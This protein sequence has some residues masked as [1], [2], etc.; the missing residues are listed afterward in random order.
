MHKRISAFLT[1]I[2]FLSFTI[3]AQQIQDQW[4][5]YRGYK[6]CGVID[7][8]NLPNYWDINQNKN[9]KW[10]KDIE[11]LGMSNPVIW[12]DKLLI[13]TA[14][15]KQD[16]GGFKAGIY[17]NIES[18]EDESEHEWQVICLNK[19]TGELIWKQTAYTGIPKQKR[20]SKSSHANSTIATDGNFIVAFFGSEGLYCFD[21]EG[22][23]K[24]TKDFGTLKSVFFAAE[25]AEWEFA[26]SP[27]I[28]EGV[29]IIQC[30]VL[31][32]SFIATYNAASGKE[33]WKKKRKE[34]PGWCTPNIYENDGKTIIAV[35]GFKHRGGYDFETGKEIWNM[36][37]GG[38]IQIP[39]PIIKDD[40]IYFNSAHG[41]SSPI[42][43]VKTSAIGDITLEKEQTTNDYIAW[44]I[45]RGGAYMQTMLIYGDYLY[46]FRWNGNIQCL[47]AKTG[48]EIYKEKLGKAESFTASPVA[49]DGKIYIPN[50]NGKV[51]VIKA[52]ETFEVIS[53]N[54]LRDLCLVTPSITKGIIYFR[55]QSGIIAIAKDE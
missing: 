36:S 45:A 51:Y 38:D 7:N 8:A 42:L 29:V 55:T 47:D 12:G 20:H 31:D 17:G 5:S 18:I 15:S 33:I 32:N 24:W 14:I 53:K 10:K 27:I 11:G 49:S 6:A 52:G 28:H 40:L 41:K 2:L 30:D 37:G 23:L 26:S 16:S 21:M 35:N 25:S 39:T 22:N 54:Y 1:F 43:A 13:T 50:D 3:Q 19:N 9:I 4:P 34:Y 48:Q 46:N 44:S